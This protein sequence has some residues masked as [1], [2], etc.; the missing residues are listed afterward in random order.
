MTENHPAMFYENKSALHGKITD[1]F[2][3]G[4]N[5]NNACFCLHKTTH[6]KCLKNCVPKK[7]NQ[8]F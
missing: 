2:V 7:Q 8:R 5:P 3:E 4:I 6:L 1:F